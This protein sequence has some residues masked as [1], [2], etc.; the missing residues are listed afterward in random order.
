MNNSVSIK[1]FHGLGDKFLDLLGFCIICKFLNYNPNVSFTDNE[2]FAWG[3]S[4]YDVRLFDFS[5]ITISNGPCDFYVDSPNSS[6]SLCPYKVYM[7][8]SRFF[9][10]ISFENISNEFS[11]YAKKIIKPS[12]IILS[13]I[14]E[15]IENAYGIHLRK[16]D[17]INN[18]GCLSHENTQNE[19]ETL[20]SKL[21]ED[22]TNIIINETEPTFLIVS[23]DD[24]WKKEIANTVNDISVKHNKQITILDIVYDVNNSINYSN[25][26]SVLDMFC[27][28]KCKEILQGVKYST[29]SMLASLLGNNKLR[30]YSRFTDTYH[31]C[32]VHSWSSAIEMNGSKNMDIEFHKHIID[33]V[34]NIH[35]NIQNIYSSDEPSTM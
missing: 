17:K 20:T 28:S 33:G 25:Y 35:T 1:L 27:L 21:L 34:A 14:P 23:E 16:T 7:F 4:N 19:F 12:E 22:V 18:W 5:D 9:P 24:S 3:N 15:N 31:N 13:N 2:Q 32:L 6:S 10:E 26:N 11:V 8:I 29:F 30:N